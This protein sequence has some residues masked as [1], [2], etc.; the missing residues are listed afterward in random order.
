MDLSSCDERQ[1]RLTPLDG[2]RGL[3]ALQSI[4]IAGCD[5]VCPGNPVCC[6]CCW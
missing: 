4:F 3:T 5:L 6:Q 1:M 2:I